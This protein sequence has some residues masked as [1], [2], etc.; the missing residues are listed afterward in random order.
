MARDLTF[1]N[2]HLL[3]VDTIYFFDET[4]DFGELEV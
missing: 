1:D 2:S 4:E 3:E